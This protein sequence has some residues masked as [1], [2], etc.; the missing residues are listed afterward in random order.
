VEVKC[1]GR[2]KE[3]IPQLFR[4]QLDYSKQYGILTDGWEWRFYRANVPQ[5]FY[6]QDIL[7]K[8]AEFLLYWNDYIKPEHYYFDVFAAF[9]QEKP[10]NLN[11]NEI[12]KIFFED[13]TNL[14]R[15]FKSKM[16]ARGTFKKYSD[17]QS[18][19]ICYAC[20]IQFVLYKV[21]VD[22]GFKQFQAQYNYYISQIKMVLQ[23]KKF[24]HAI[25]QNIRDISTYIADN[26]YKPFYEEQTTINTQLLRELE[27]SHLIDL[28]DV[29]PWFDIFIFISKYQFANLK[30]EIFGFVYENYLK[31][32]SKDKNEN[33]GQYFTAPAVVN[34]ML[35]A[36]GFTVENIRKNPEKISLID[37]AC[38][39]GTFL[40]SAV[41]R[42]INA[43][44]DNT[45]TNAKIIEK[46]VDRNIFG[47]DVEEFPL[48]LAEMSILMRLLPLIVNDN[49]SNPVE[50]K[51]KLFKTKDSISE[52]W[53]TGIDAKESEPDLFSHLKDVKLDYQSFM[54]D[55]KNV[56]GMLQSMQGGKNHRLR[57]DYVLANPPYI[58]YKECSQM[59]MPFLQLIKGK[60]NDVYGVNLHS[61]PS[62]HKK[63]AP[64]PNLFAFFVALGLALLKDDGKVCFIVP[65]TLLTAE[66][67]DVLRYHLAKNTTIE[68]IVTFGGN[69]FVERGLS[70]KKA[71]STSSLIFVANKTAP[72]TEHNV[73]ILNYQPYIE[74]EKL[75]IDDYLKTEIPKNNFI[76][77]TELL[78]KAENWHFLINSDSENLFC[79]KYKENSQNISCYYDHTQ[80]RTLFGDRFYFDRGLKYPKDKVNKQFDYGNQD[81]IF[82][83]PEI[84]KYRLEVKRTDSHIVKSLLNFPHGSQGATVFAKKYK[85][86]WKY[87]N[88]DNFN[89]SKEQIMIDYN[90]V[91]ISSDCKSEMLYLLAILNSK[92]TEKVLKL[93]LH[94]A[95]EQDLTVGIKSI[96]QYIG[97]P[98][99][100]AENKHVKE[101]IIKKVEDLLDKVEDRTL[102][103]LVDFK[104]FTIQRFENVEVAGKNLVL[105]FSGKDY[106]LPI[107]EN[108]ELVKRVIESRHCGESRNPLSIE[109]EGQFRNDDEYVS[110][111][112]LKNLETIDF[113]QQQRLKCEIDDLVYQLYFGD[114]TEFKELLNN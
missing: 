103:N 16:A 91:L 4:Y 108:S 19:E 73:Q 47:L 98:I 58:S 12:R 68:Q 9:G 105:T 106:K 86:I 35:D 50:N 90:N 65:Q 42:M 109:F 28:D 55:D 34:Y 59:K 75:N 104:D 41:D 113:E 24:Y 46:L 88:Y 38:G 99:I 1:F 8:P 112:E 111:Q 79:Q 21:L 84:K 100:T 114:E 74:N 10:M 101:L 3:G 89:F 29:A 27:N 102:A 36:V 37:P 31:D 57:F 5:I 2:I 39:A 56:L 107:K 61:I 45:E 49:F 18:I 14:I 54:R 70:Q 78:E 26:I 22:N 85:I 66:A 69:L 53:D 13:T 51:L 81:N 52:F 63:F 48:Y 71:I 110:L 32:L 40:Y 15:K 87:M 82:F 43:F 7:E 44:N 83:M 95:N 20:L 33:W 96:K 64:S 30:N 6:L 80:S 94:L 17:K 76:A 77:Q 62:N 97:I 60:M 92:V 11:D 25:I 93:Y 72:T 67:L 23:T